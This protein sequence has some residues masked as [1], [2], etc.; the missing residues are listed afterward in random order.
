MDGLECGAKVIYASGH[1]THKK[2][3][4]DRVKKG[5]V[6]IGPETVRKFEFGRLDLTGAFY[7]I[8]V[9]AGISRN[10]GDR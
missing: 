2:G 5:Y 1:A 4:D 9:L 3:R 6:T 10:G 8:F 7:K